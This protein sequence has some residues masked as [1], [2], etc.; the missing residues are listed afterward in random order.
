MPRIPRFVIA[1]P[2][3]G[4][5]K[6]TIATG[7]MAAFARRYIVQGFKVGPD[8]IDP[9]YHTAA[10]K[11][12]SRNLDTWM[13]SKEQVKNIFMRAKQ[14]AD[15]YIIEGVMGL[16]DG[17]DGITE[18]GST[19][20][21]AKLLSAPVILVIDAGK[22]ARS[23]AAIALGFRE[24]DPDLNLAGVIVNNVG[25]EKHAQ[26]VTEAI[27]AIGVQVIGCVPRLEKLNVPERHLGLIITKEREAATDSF[28]REAASVVEKY[29]DVG[30][31]FSIAASAP[32]LVTVSESR[33]ATQPQSN[34]RIAVARDDAFCFYYEDNLDLLRNLGAEIAF[35]SP[36]HDTDI[37]KNIS[38][39]YL[40]GGYPELYAPQLA[41]NI[42]LR[43]AIKNIAS[44][45]IPVYAECGGLMF[46]TRCLVDQHGQEHAMLDIIPGHARMTNH[47]TMGYREVETLQDTFLLLKNMTVRGHEFHYS[48]WVREDE[49]LPCAYAIKLGGTSDTQLEGFTSGNVLATYVHIHFACNPDLPKNFVDA[50]GA[51]LTEKFERN[52]FIKT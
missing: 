44:Q 31:V 39:I 32:D 4:S 5:G 27:D 46:L 9:G 7:L 48:E 10:T 52:A 26:W 49:N 12:I 16:F 25:S 17:Y 50:V 6:T 42:S 3:S 29:V 21:F 38:G 23:A 40:G 37:P 36:L 15:L 24:F 20:E 41:D 18:Q 22:M 1:A 11:R 14:N 35:F 43:N 28:I 45:K 34:V 51:G 19:A 47:L 2:S 8:Y 33:T 13:L 30:K